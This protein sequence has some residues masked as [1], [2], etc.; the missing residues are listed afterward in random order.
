LIESIILK[1]LEKVE[2]ENFQNF[3]IEVKIY[4]K[5]IYGKA[6]KNKTLIKEPQIIY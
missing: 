4:N 2:I 6:L 1:N 5:D 3:D